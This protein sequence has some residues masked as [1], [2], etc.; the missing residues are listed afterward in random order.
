[1]SK[2]VLAIDT[3]C[4]DTAAAIVRGRRVLSNIVASQDQLHS[5][6]GGVVP[7]LARLNHQQIIDEVIATA[8][9]RAGINRAEIELIAVTKGPGLAIALEVGLETAW[10]LKE[11]LGVEMVAINHMEGHLLSPFGQNR[12]G[13]ASTISNDEGIGSQLGLLISGGHTQLVEVNG[14]GS[15]QVIGQTLDD[16]CGEAFDK[17]A[18]LL[19]LGYPGGPVLAKL[20]EQGRAEYQSEIY[21]SDTKY[22]TRITKPLH[23]YELSL[24]IPLA[25][26][27]TLDMSFSGLKTA[28]WQLVAKVLDDV[29]VSNHENYEQER[30]HGVEIGKQ[31][32]GALAVLFETTAVTAVV[33]K[34][35]LALE[36][37]D[38]ESILVGGGVA[39]NNLLRKELRKLAHKYKTPVHFAYT[40]KLNRDNA[41]MIGLAA[42][43]YQH[44]RTTEKPD[45]LPN[46]GI[47]DIG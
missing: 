41:A 23:G 7:S 44:A 26:Q 40:K 32:R 13:N 2:T 14:P 37:G 42:S 5:Q 24:P 31:L 12:N 43:I 6:H 11:E 46:W 15:Y 38:Y 21:K 29:D 10:H 27:G 4:D 47:D 19:G 1:M 39:N 36:R 3:S 16:A 8:V 34:V 25:E 35:D 9:T 20:A 28:F 17:S 45:R 33:M 22:R 30:K 18:R